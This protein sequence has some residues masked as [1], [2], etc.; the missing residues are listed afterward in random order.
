[1]DARTRAIVGAYKLGSA[2]ARLLPGPIATLAG[3]GIGASMAV[4]DAERRR[5]V[6]LHQQRVH[7]GALS[8]LALRRAVQRTF[9][10]YARY[11]VEA[12][13]LPGLDAAALDAGMTYEGLEHIEAAREAGTGAIMAIPHLGGWDFG[14]AWIATQ[15]VPI[16]VIVEPLEPPELFEWFADFRRSLGM[17]VVPLGPDAANAS[18]RALREN[19]ILCL[20]CDR[21][22]GGGGVEVEFFGER[23][24]LPAGPITLALRTGA[25]VLPCAVYYRADG[26]HGVVRPPLDLTRT[27]RMRDDVQRLTQALAGELESLIRKAPEQWH[28]MSPNWPSDRAS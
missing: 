28:L 3:R 27:G 7:G 21:D 14:G 13:R 1:L 2:A 6:G 25:P 15:G 17:T 9:D 8:P 26:H 10:S 18:L 16:T 4:G 19:H 11:W 22:I 12:F 23:T 5:L 24:T 20:L